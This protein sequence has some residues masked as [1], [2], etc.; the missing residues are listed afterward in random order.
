MSLMFKIDIYLTGLPTPL[1]MLFE[2]G[3]G[4]RS[5]FDK[6]DK[7]ATEERPEYLKDDAGTFFAFRAKLLIA[8]VLGKT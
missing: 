1:T 5:M 3:A 8:M 4:A 7:M 6:I 2:D